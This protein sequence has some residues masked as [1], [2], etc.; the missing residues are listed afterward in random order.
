[1]FLLQTSPWFFQVAE[2][3]SF[4]D[5]VTAAAQKDTK[6]GDDWWFPR[7]VSDHID[8]MNKNMI[9]DW[10]WMIQGWWFKVDDWGLIDD[11][12]LM[13]FSRFCGGRMSHRE[14]LTLLFATFCPL[15][16][17]WDGALFVR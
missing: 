8:D 3:R 7:N 9:E 12:W 5:L 1:M 13:I 6:A 10:G 15:W 4:R 14:Y 17:W 16:F 11:W 2:S